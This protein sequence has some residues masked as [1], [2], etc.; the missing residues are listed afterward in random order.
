[1][2]LLIKMRAIPLL[3]V[4]IDVMIHLKNTSEP[5]EARLE[6]ELK[7]A[8]LELYCKDVLESRS[9]APPHVLVRIIRPFASR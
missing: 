3:G 2:R 6:P 8:V 1:M 9:T 5:I 4:T 7:S